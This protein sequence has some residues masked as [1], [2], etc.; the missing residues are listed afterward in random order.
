ML[1]Y[2][3]LESATV[4]LDIVEKKYSRDHEAE[5]DQVGA[6]VTD[7][8]GVT[9]ETMQR[10]VCNEVEADQVGT[11]GGY[12]RCSPVPTLHTLLQVGVLLASRACFDPY[13]AQYLFHEFA[14][15]VREAGGEESIELL[16]THPLHATREAAVRSQVA[17]G[18]EE[19][20]SC[21][22]APVDLRER[23][24]L[25]KKLEMPKLRRLTCSERP[26]VTRCASAT[27]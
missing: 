24:H 8:T 16:S 1:L 22:C 27:T 14:R 21:G 18:M 20:C 17:R 13:H 15:G 23:R 11:D 19:R 5:A 6:D 12:I 3:G 26:P 9:H 4:P 10:N 2:F 25:D 7:V